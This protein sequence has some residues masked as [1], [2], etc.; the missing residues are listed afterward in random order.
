MVGCVGAR[1]CVVEGGDGEGDCRFF[2]FQAEDGIRDL[3]RSRGLGD[4]YKRQVYTSL[5]DTTFLSTLTIAENVCNVPGPAGSIS[6][7]T[8]ICG[9]STNTYFINPVSGATSYV[10]SLPPGW[11][12][13]STTNSINATSNS[14]IGEISVYASNACGDGLFST[15]F[16]NVDPAMGPTIN[17]THVT[18]FGGNDGSAAGFPNGGTS[19]YTYSWLPQ[20]GS[21]AIANS[22]TSGT[23]TVTISDAIGCTASATVSITQPTEIIIN[24]SSTAATCG[25]CAG[26][27]AICCLIR[28]SGTSRSGPTCRW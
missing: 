2:F 28:A 11:T 6:G 7:A 26:A 13:N 16:I 1:L 23:Y 24:T 9:G 20:G 12:G 25:M 14:T 8:T 10:W 21:N 3:V 19:P 17:P 5:G 15:L 22:L 18:C 27:T 4:V